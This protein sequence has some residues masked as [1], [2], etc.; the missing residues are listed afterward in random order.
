MN[1]VSPYKYFWWIASI[2][3]YALMVYLLIQR[4]NNA[5]GYGGYFLFC[6][7]L[8]SLVYHLIQCLNNAEGYGGCFF[9]F[10]L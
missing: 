10:Y 3:F 2:A 4:L 7:F 1:T 8:R 6:F 5:E 9:P